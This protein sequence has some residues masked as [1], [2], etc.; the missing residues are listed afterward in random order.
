M[1]Y[2]LGVTQRQS[3]AGCSERAR[4]DALLRSSNRIRTRVQRGQD[5]APIKTEHSKA[6]DTSQPITVVFS[7]HHGGLVGLKGSHKILEPEF[8]R[9]FIQFLG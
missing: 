7:T 4:D 3:I 6:G 8:L 9:L 5:L 2:V 1:E